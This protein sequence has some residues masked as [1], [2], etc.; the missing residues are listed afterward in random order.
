MTSTAER[1]AT[2]FEAYSALR[3]QE[4]EPVWLRQLRDE[5]W[6]SF[7]EKGFPT[8][9]DED[10]RFTNLATLAK[11]PFRRAASTDVASVSKQIAAFRLSGAASQL[12]FVNG[13]FA[14][15]CSSRSNSRSKTSLSTMPAR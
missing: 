9:H 11:T 4:R 14:P 3:A 8:T 13:T 7:S 2:Y 5:A 10:W 1:L 6:T 12:V 15:E